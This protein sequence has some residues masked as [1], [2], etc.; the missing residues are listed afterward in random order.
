MFAKEPAMVAKLAP[1]LGFVSS[2]I[3]QQYV[4]IT[5]SHLR[6]RNIPMMTTQRENQIL[7]SDLFVERKVM[8][9][10]NALKRFPS[11][12]WILR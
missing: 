9:R 2:N 5:Q 6:W 1:N 11:H 4:I 3:L 12:V 10:E 8:F 7:P